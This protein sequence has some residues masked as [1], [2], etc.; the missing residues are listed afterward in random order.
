MTS[1]VG[2]EL[3]RLASRRLFRLAA[4]A[5]VLGI[6]IAGIVLAAKSHRANLAVLE[7]QLRREQRQQVEQCLAGGF[8][9]E[10]VPPGMTLE[11]FCKQTTFVGEVQDPRFH[12]TQLSNVLRGTTVPLVLLAWVLAA[13]FIGAEWHA[14]TVSTLLTWEPRRLR[15]LGAKLLAVIL[16]AFAATILIQVL[17]GLALTPAAAFRGTTE[18]VRASWAISVGGVVLRGA[19]LAAVGAAIGFS[20]AAVARNTAA[21]MG[22][23]FAYMLILENLIGTIRPGWRSWFVGPNAFILVDGY[24]HPEIAP[25]SVV[26]AGLLLGIYAIGFVLTAAVFFERRDV[27]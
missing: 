7:A 10:A 24:R 2:V 18:G 3:R 15:V 27:T 23:G 20:I 14:G 17:L 25:R 8:P 1:L 22:V 6:V 13:S 26:Q 4:A 21:A 12:L 19:A 11:E 9:P 5:V 16:I